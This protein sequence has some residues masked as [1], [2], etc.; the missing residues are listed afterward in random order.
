M[1]GP[2]RVRFH[3]HRE[4]KKG[5]SA[6]F[7]AAAD[8][9]QGLSS[10]LSPIGSGQPNESKNDL[11]APFAAAADE[12]Q[13]SSATL[14]LSHT[15]QERLDEM[16]NAPGG[17]RPAGSQFSEEKGGFHDNFDIPGKT[18]SSPSHRG[19]MGSDSSSPLSSPGQLSPFASP[20]CSPVK[21]IPSILSGVEA[22]YIC[23][24][25]VNVRRIK[26]LA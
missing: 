23:G 15:R 7:A 18:P 8:D 24:K 16:E 9:L 2:K 13:D 10:Y 3:D 22:N 20:F 6:P 4:T 11:S 17:L 26:H 21:T 12:F 19:T 25:P 14:P 1:H 5:S